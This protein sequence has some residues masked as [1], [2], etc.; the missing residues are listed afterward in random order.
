M[1]LDTYK[2]ALIKNLVISFDFFCAVMAI[3]I[4]FFKPIVFCFNCKYT[5]THYSD[6]FG[7]H[8]ESV[9]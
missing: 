7:V 3:Y 5:G 8:E 6:D 9:L 2:N 4:I 1:W